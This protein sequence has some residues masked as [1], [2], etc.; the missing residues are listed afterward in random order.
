M[1]GLGFHSSRELIDADL[2]EPVG[3]HDRG[4][5]GV[6]VMHQPGEIRDTLPAAGPDRHLECVEDRLVTTGLFISIRAR[7][8]NCQR[9]LHGRSGAPRPSSRPGPRRGLAAPGASM[10]LSEHAVQ[11]RPRTLELRPS[12]RASLSR[13]WGAGRA[14]WCPAGDPPGQYMVELPP[15][16]REQRLLPEQGR[17]TNAWVIQRCRRKGAR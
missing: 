2:S 12:S 3:E 14:A 5:A 13:A 9:Q 7:R 8:P 4:D 10:W 1:V 16:R 15:R 6:V 11:C 17:W